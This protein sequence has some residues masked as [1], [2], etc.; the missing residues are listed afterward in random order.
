[1]PAPL[2][3]AIILNY[4][5]P[6]Y[7]LKCAEAL[8][9]QSSKLKADR[10]LEIFVIDNHSQDESMQWFHNR[11]NGDP[12]VRI[13]ES[14]TN[15]G[16]AGGNALAIGR[17]RG[18]YLLIINPDNELQSGALQ[19]MIEAMENDPSIGIVAPKLVHEDGTVR[20]SVRR[21]PSPLDVLFKRTALGRLFPDTVAR[22]R[23]LDQDPDRSRD[24]DWAVGA[25]LLIRRDLYEQLGG[26]DPR[27]FLFF[28]D[29]DLCRRTWAAGK[30][31]RY[32][33]EAVATDRKKRLSEGGL[34]Q[35]LTKRA[36]R[37]HVASAVRY[38][39][40]WGWM[41]NQHSRIDR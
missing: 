18:T 3:S 19:N 32:L 22:Y 35:L 29:I 38:F 7:A 14:P 10:S 36:G 28:E 23:G 2:V 27:F 5:T 20:D 12:L 17:A 21:F 13:L 26:F 39:A 6:R 33:P 24:V 1:M 40:K 16:Y 9:T 8:K 15:K 34:W 37:A 25:C 31:V 41:R 30:R 11:L 4:R